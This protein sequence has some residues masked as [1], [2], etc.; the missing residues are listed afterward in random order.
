MTHNKRIRRRCGKNLFWL[1][2]STYKC[3]ESPILFSRKPHL[4][5]WPY[6][7]YEY[8]EQNIWMASHEEYFPKQNILER[9]PEAK[10]GPVPVKLIIGGCFG[11]NKPDMYIQRYNDNLFISTHTETVYLGG[12][13]GEKVVRVPHLFRI[14]NKL[15]PD[16]TEESGIVGVIIVRK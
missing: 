4:V 9:I 12:I 1:V 8:E 13:D 16:V 7:Q 2:K 3:N 6:H 5:N 15:F 10:N 14:S 11:E